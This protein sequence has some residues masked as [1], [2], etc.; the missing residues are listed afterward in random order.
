M[1]IRSTL[2]LFGILLLG[3]G[4]FALLQ[5]LDIKPASERAE[6][7]M[8]LLPSLNLEKQPGMGQT[9]RVTVNPSTFSTIKIERAATGEQ[10]AA[11]WEWMRENNQWKMVSP[12]PFRVDENAVSGLLSQ[13]A[14]AQRESMSGL[15]SS[16]ADY[17]LDKPQLTVTLT[18]GDKSYT[19][20]VGKQGPIA[21]DPIYY[22]VSSES[23]SKPMAVKKSRIEKLFEPIGYYRNKRFFTSSFGI[24]EIQLS[25]ASRELLH[26]KLENNRWKYVQPLLGDADNGMV[27]LTSTELASLQVESPSDFVYDGAL[28]DDVLK[29]YG[30]TAGKEAYVITLKQPAPGGN[31][32]QIIT[33]TVRIGM[34]ESADLIG[35]GQK[36][37]LALI[38]SP[39]AWG[40]PVH[41]A[42]VVDAKLQVNP[43]GSAKIYYALKEGEN[44]IMR[45]RSP[46][47]TGTWPIMATLAKKV[48]EFRSRQLL[49]L[50][51]PKL[52]AIDFT[53]GS[54]QMRLRRPELKPDGS[55]PANWQI[56]FDQ[57]AKVAA[58][59]KVV[60]NLINACQKVAMHDA[61]G[62]LDDEGRQ[63][64]WFG[65]DPVDMGFDKPQAMLTFWLDALVRDAQ[66]K[67][68]NENDPIFKD[69]IKDKFTAR[70]TIGKK[71]DK[72]HV[73]YVKREMPGLQPVILAIPDPWIQAGN[74]NLP[75]QMNA[76]QSYSLSQL[77]SG[78]YLAFREHAL[79]SMRADLAQTMTV[80]RNNQLLELVK[81]EKKD[82]TGS[83]SWAWQMTKPVKSSSNAAEFVLD[84]LNQWS[85]QSLISDRAT[86]K[87][88]EEK[89]GLGSKPFM[90]YTIAT[91]PD[92]KGK[93]ESYSYIIG[94]KI[95]NQSAYPNHVYARLEVQ[96]ASGTA[97]ESNQLV[98][99]LPWTMVQTLD[100]ELHDTIIFPYEPNSKPNTMTF[101]W[102]QSVDGKPVQT[103]MME[104]KWDEAKKEWSISQWKDSQGKAM[105]DL[106]KLD[107]AKIE[108]MLAASGMPS[109][110]ATGPRFNPLQAHRFLIYSGTLD[111]AWRLQPSHAT[112][113]PSLI[114]ELKYAQGTN[115]TLV[116]G[117][118]YEPKEADM[119][120]LAG[121]KFILASSSTLPGA[122]FLVEE[123]GYGEL[124]K[125]PDYFFLPIP[126]IPPAP[127]SPAPT[128]PTPTVPKSP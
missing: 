45:L 15:S 16:L 99:A 127:S 108:G 73:V 87:D 101:Q 14:S 28:S 80:L 47:P 118:A 100:V 41:L 27:Q 49:S 1:K 75:Q 18:K 78:G 26:L 94:K 50:D 79:P 56:Y 123:S 36:A 53:S 46:Q 85:A 29:K 83:I 97:P 71:D 37:G 4:I 2:I 86:A 39:F 6:L 58:D 89:F 110:R 51:V 57:R 125:R 113:P 30:L 111:P 33:E 84:N 63:K 7:S 112:Q 55:I 106:P 35:Q 20:K 92:D 90:K 44:S 17:G 122:A 21:Q 93:A 67:V 88:W 40:W 128:V 48:D 117:T 103:T 59:L 64:A 5:I 82:D 54:D 23:D 24:N 22:V 98:F 114:I 109:S 77:V 102:N 104:M 72:R 10:P 81:E 126:G 8:Y 121:R 65:T 66:G 107:Q 19:V 34:V 68:T 120:S 115:R 25:G 11:I 105:A 38:S 9:T 74:P 76:M 62:F 124:C 61:K 52:D 3:L 119:P 60:E 42:A 31:P 12:Q 69:G 70:L 96:P 116:L 13:I 95:E 91:K 32:A 43:S